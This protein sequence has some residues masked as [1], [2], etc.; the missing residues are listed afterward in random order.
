[1]DEFKFGLSNSFRR[2]TI[3]TES[4][5]GEE[6]TGLLLNAEI[7]LKIAEARDPDLR[8]STERIRARSGLSK[9][10]TL[11]KEGWLSIQ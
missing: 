5:E 4:D 9:F 7:A 6:E 10:E 2:E 3:S 11:A 1:M 8:R